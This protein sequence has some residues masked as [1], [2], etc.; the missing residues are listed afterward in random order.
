[1]CFNSTFSRAV[2]PGSNVKTRAQDQPPAPPLMTTTSVS[3]LPPNNPPSSRNPPVAT[4][5]LRLFTQLRTYTQNHLSGHSPV[6][7]H[8]PHRNSF[9]WVVGRGSH[10]SSDG[11]A[12]PAPA[13]VTPV[14]TLE[15]T[16]STQSAPEHLVSR[17]VR[18][19]EDPGSSRTAD[20]RSSES[21]ESEE[22]MVRN[23]A[24]TMVS[25]TGGHVAS[26]E[27]EISSPMST[28]N[29]DASAD[30]HRNKPTV[31]LFSYQDPAQSGRP[32]L[33]FPTI[34]RT[35]PR[36]TSIVKVGRYSDRDGIPIITPLNPSEAP[37]GFR[38]K[39][40][41]RK[42]CEFSYIGNQWHIKDIGSSSGTFLNHVRL[43]PPSIPSRLYPI[44]DGD[45]I[46]LGVDF[47]GGE[48]EI[49]RCVRIRI[50][51]NRAWQQQ[52]NEFK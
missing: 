46:Q 28:T 3:G 41:S 20:N 52:A 15:P 2:K 17:E 10:L 23:R 7:H 37:V 50:E 19:E 18:A 25:T 9:S 8:R 49:F 44:R 51:C 31:R 40:V 42:H 22:I 29:G 45:V 48:E 11:P 21:N 27:I 5:P 24:V 34:T 1:M 33:S 13:P 30:T 6:G 38:S 39:V 35:L 26:P 47:K 12:E 4:G 14:D 32:S 43:S 36:E 16:T